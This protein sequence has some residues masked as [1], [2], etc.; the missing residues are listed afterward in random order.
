MNHAVDHFV[1]GAV[2]AQHQDQVRAR[3]HGL[4][5]DPGGVAGAGS[6][7]ELGR[8]ARARQSF[9]GTLKNALGIPPEFAGGGV[10]D[11]DRLPIACNLSSIAP[12]AINRDIAP[13][14]IEELREK[15]RHHEYL[16]YVLDAPEIT[17]A[18][19]DAMMR[20]LKA[21]E[22][23][24]SGTGDAG[25]SH[26]AR[27]RE[28]ARR[29]RQGGAFEPHAEPG[30]RAGRRGT[31]RFRSPRA[32]TLLRDEAFAYVAELK[33]D[34]LSLAVHYRDGKSGAGCDARRRRHRRRRHGKRA[35]HPLHSAALEGRAA[36]GRCAAKW[37]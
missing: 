30:Q 17:D 4:P 20:E 11:Q 24:A 34:G 32:R 36:T 28:A 3:R 23:S 26:P 16:Y 12:I 8:K 10:V 19:Y 15:L 31:A 25:F 29:L 22:A 33:M 7:R 18:E 13:Q 27:R 35:D 14:K 6:R 1:D 5:R 9:S 37:C 21:L 2:A